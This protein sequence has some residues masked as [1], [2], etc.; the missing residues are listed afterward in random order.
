MGG[1]YWETPTCWAFGPTAQVEA[2]TN[3]YYN[4]HIDADLSEQ[5]IV[6]KEPA[7]VSHGWYYSKALDHFKNEGVPD[8]S[9]LSYSAS[10]SN[11]D[12]LCENPN[13][14]IRITSYNSISNNETSI[15]QNLM[16]Q[17][18]TVGGIP[19]TWYNGNTE[20]H[21]MLLIG[22]GVIDEDT[23]SIIGAPAVPVDNSWY[24][25][26]YWIYKNSYGLNDGYNGFLYIL[27]SQGTKPRS[28]TRVNIPIFSLN[29]T[30]S[31][32]NCNDNDG[33]GYY[34]WGVGA[35]PA[36]CPS[37]PDEPDG[38]DSNPGLGPLTSNGQC[39]I[40]NSYTS[41]FEDGWNNWI[42]VNDDDSDWWRHAG[43]PNNSNSSH[44]HLGPQQASEGDYYI[45][46]DGTIIG[47]VPMKSSIIESPPINLSNC[48]AGVIDFDYYQAACLWGNPDKSEIK[49]QVSYDN[50][51]TWEDYWNVINHQDT[52]WHHATIPFS[53]E[54]NKIRSVG[55][56]GL[57]AASVVALDNISIKPWLFSN[58]TCIID[59]NVEWQKDVRGL[60]SVLIIEKEGILTIKNTDVSIHHDA[61]VVINP[62]GRLILDGAK[63]TNSC[64][65][66][67]WPGIQVWGDKSTH[68][69]AVNGSFGQGYLELKNGAAIENA[70]C[71]VELWRPG[72]W[73]TT[74]GIVHVTDAVF[75]NNH[76]SVH[77][78]HYKNSHPVSGKETGY[79]ATFT[80]CQF[81]VDGDYPGDGDHVF[82]KHVDLDHVRG[83]KFRA[84]DLSVAA[85]SD[86]IS[87]WTSGI[88]GYEAGFSV[89]G[90]CENNSIPPCPSYDNSTFSGFFTAVS[91][92]NDGTRT[93]PAITVT[94]SSFNNNDFGVYVSNLGN[95]SVPFLASALGAYHAFFLLCSLVALLQS[96]SQNPSVS[97]RL[98]F[99]LS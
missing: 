72:H 3:L 51:D 41:T 99:A 80:R 34:Y 73:G 8:E 71:A 65:G 19:Y 81:T 37:C 66:E 95:V 22:W 45:Y 6:C 31:D 91:A 63:L 20:S 68:Q 56:I 74:G 48:C 10:V 90:L 39:T 26:T 30:D 69:Y 29:K 75:R 54:V 35:K 86:N 13:E 21:C 97:W 50:G 15:R 55:T 14:R 32:I 60:N 58:D 94:H 61:H 87:Y 28:L 88:A 93:P 46:I 12:D 9:C 49:L 23:P 53:R 64:S 57:Y 17:P 11:C 1:I 38:D 77:A 62:G 4:E 47:N 89:S 7:G 42:Q 16:D 96:V 70:E 83:L 76:R 5:Y 79:N 85:P 40:I 92:V 67:L 52:V 27:H 82:H 59:H 84:C 24:G 33:D 2:L 25:T 43:E 44:Y 78:L 36:H 18:L 98:S